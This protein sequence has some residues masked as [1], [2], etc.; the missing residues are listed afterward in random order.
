[1]TDPRYEVELRDTEIAA[2]I[3]NGMTAV[4]GEDDDV[5]TGERSFH[6]TEMGQM[7]GSEDPAISFR[8]GPKQNVTVWDED[9]AAIRPLEGDE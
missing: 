3:I 1:M 9:I 5:V 4:D 2:E 7:D 6:A 8:I